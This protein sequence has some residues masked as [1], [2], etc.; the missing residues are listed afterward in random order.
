MLDFEI[1]T[2]SQEVAK[3]VQGGPV[4]PHPIPPV[5]TSYKNMELEKKKNCGAE[6]CKQGPGGRKS[7]I[8][9]NSRRT[10]ANKEKQEPPDSQEIT[11]FG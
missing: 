7:R 11:H 8:S 6:K 9:V 3:I 5:A 1:I 4:S 2:D 10:W